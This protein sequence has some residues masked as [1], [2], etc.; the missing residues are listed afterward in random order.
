M[1]PLVPMRLSTT[2][3]FLTCRLLP[4][5]FSLF[6]VDLSFVLQ[7]R[8]L[9]QSISTIDQE[10]NKQ[11]TCTSSH[12][13]PSKIWPLGSCGGLGFINGLTVLPRASALRAVFS[14]TLENKRDAKETL[15]QETAKQDRVL[16]PEGQL[17]GNEGLM[18]RTQANSRGL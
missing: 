5:G 13:N 9:S 18:K 15:T 12:F 11:K 8:K 4:I 2:Q 7:P 16:G 3:A 14:F 17:V 6:L 10:T 1:W